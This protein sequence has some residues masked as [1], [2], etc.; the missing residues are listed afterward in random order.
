MADSPEIVS[1]VHTQNC[2]I[3]TQ[4]HLNEYKNTKENGRDKMRGKENNSTHIYQV[5]LL[6]GR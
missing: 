2:Y 3:L 4:V 6:T 5:R 1:H